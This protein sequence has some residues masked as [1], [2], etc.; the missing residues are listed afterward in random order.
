MLQPNE[1]TK[2]EVFFD[3]HPFTGAK[4][5]TVY[6]PTE[7]KRF[8]EHQFWV[9][10]NSRDDLAFFPNR[11][12]LGIITRGDMPTA[13]MIVTVP[14]QPK[15]QLTGAKCD[16]EFIQVKVQELD[17]GTKRAIFQ[18]SATVAAGIPVGELHARVELTTSNPAMP[19]LVVPVSVVIESSR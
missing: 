3:T 19:K 12:D 2:I 1:A 4:T 14:G 11:L 10:A 17:R 15:L 6:V 7:G 5:Q 9:Q 18:I 13:H 16:S 8:A